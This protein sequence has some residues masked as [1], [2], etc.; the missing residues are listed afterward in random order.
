MKKED[1][2]SKIRAYLNQYPIDI[3]YL[4][5]SHCKGT[6]QKDS[7]IDIGVLLNAEQKN[8]P[9]KTILRKIEADLTGL[10]SQPVQVESINDAP[11][12][13]KHSIVL[14]SD[15]IL[16]KEKDQRI[17]LEVSTLH[18]Y[19]DNQCI[20]DIPYQTLKRKINYES[21]T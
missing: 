16:E 12:L 21:K 11:P 17:K 4:Y 20:F 1:L 5:G 7:D 9:N 8:L 18:E 15:L 3:A 19:E 13:L 10:L 6:A 2:K 14:E